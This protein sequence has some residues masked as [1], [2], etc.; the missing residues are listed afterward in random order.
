MHYGKQIEPGKRIPFSLILSPTFWIFS[1]F[2]SFNSFYFYSLRFDWSEKL[3]IHEVQYDE[4]K[5][6]V[7]QGLIQF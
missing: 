1:M 4:S 6:Q 3:D 7:K 5:E 2:F